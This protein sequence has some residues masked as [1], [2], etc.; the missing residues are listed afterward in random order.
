MEE[1][2][3]RSDGAERISRRKLIAATGAASVTGLAG[4]SGGSG[5][6]GNGN[7]GG[8]NGN[9]NGNG[10]GGGEPEKPDSITV[11]AWGG[12]WQDNL[13]EYVSTP[14]TEET[15]IEVEYDN[16]DEDQMQAQIRTALQQDREPPVNVQWSLTKTSFQSFELEL[17]EPL[18]TDVAP[19]ITNL[20]DAAKPDAGDVEWPF[21][22]LYSYTYALTYNTDEIES[23]P[24]SWSMWWDDEWQNQIGLYP[25][26][27]GITPLLA[28]MTDTE[29]GPVEE[30]GPIWDEYESLRPNVG[31]IGEDSE[32]TQS[33]R[34]G[35]VAMAVLLPANIVNAQ[36][37]G[38]PVDYTIPEEGA[39]AGRDTMWVPR[40]QSES[41]TYWS[42][43]YINTAASDEVIGPWC[44]NLGVAPLYADAEIPT[45]MEED[46]AYP[47]DEEQFNQMIVPPLDIMTEYEP[48]WESR[49]N[50]IMGS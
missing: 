15:G 21:V 44:V 27:H 16:S 39:R 32:L 48:N 33:L 37:D 13:D 47:T 29:L 6:G 8:G 34:Q 43:K 40:G 9:G 24:T 25:S 19:N 18:D 5:N 35:E 28:E 30:M 1:Q 38:A 46:L 36:D 10:N 31:T 23:E 17:I 42:Q 4:C 7:G 26:G 41:E 50:E 20:L 14:F 49:V 12:A 45:W 3:Q 22:N 11:R 2:T